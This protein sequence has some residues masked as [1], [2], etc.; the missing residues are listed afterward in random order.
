MKERKIFLK[1]LPFFFF[2]FLILVHYGYASA[3]RIISLT[4]SVTEML[5]TIGAGDQ[6]AAVTTA[7][8]Y[9]PV[10]KMLPKIGGVQISYEKILA[11]KP[12][13]VVGEKSLVGNQLERLK[14]LGVHTLA[15]NTKTLW[16][17]PASLEILGEKTGHFKKAETAASN[18]LKALNQVKKK[19]D[20]P[21]FPRVFVELGDH[22]LLTTGRTSFLSEAIQ[23][24]GGKNIGDFLPKGFEMI[25][26]E[27]VVAKNPQVIILADGET[28]HEIAER[29]GWSKVSAV[30]NKKI[31]SI[32]PDLVMRPDTRILISILKMASWFHPIP[33]ASISRA[34]IRSR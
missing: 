1:S 24:A 21:P 12:D 16:D 30:L 3:R 7:D 15:L 27:E 19:F 8:D 33:R 14:Q 34:P 23:I 18:F 29:P 10:V 17:I 13:L 25:S 22:P 32:N 20:H 5:F 11:L 9:P 6:V 31:Y 26:E 28:A 4:P 2:L